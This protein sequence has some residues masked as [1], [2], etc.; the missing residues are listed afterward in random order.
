MSA[1]PTCAVFDGNKK[2]LPSSA[3]RQSLPSSHVSDL[4][5]LKIDG[6]FTAINVKIL[7]LLFSCLLYVAK[8]TGIVIN[9][10]AKL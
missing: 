1:K 10:M 6:S 4:I 8:A 3:S 5:N 2:A 7:P 9:I